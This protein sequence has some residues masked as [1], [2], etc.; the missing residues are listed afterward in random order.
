MTIFNRNKYKPLTAPPPVFIHGVSIMRRDT[1]LSENY[2]L[3]YNQNFITINYKGITYRDATN[4]I[5]KYRLIGS[6]N[7]WI[8]T[9]DRQIIYAFLRPGKYR[10]EVYAINSEGIES[11]HSAAINFFIH[12][13][14][15]QTWWFFSIILGFIALLILS[16]IRYRTI[17]LKKQHLLQNDLNKYRQQALVR[18]M[19]PHFVFNTLNSIQSFIIKNDNIASIQYLSK[20]SRLMRLILNN[21][22]KQEVRLRDEIDALNLYMELESMRFKHKFEYIINVDNSIDADLSFI[23][24][25]IVQPFI[26]NAIWHG[27]M[28]LNGPGRIKVDFIADEDLIVCT[29]EDNGIGRAR[30]MELKSDSGSGKSSM[31]ISITETRLALLSSFYGVKLKVTFTDVLSPDNEVIGTKVHVNLPVKP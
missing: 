8:Y 28:N 4:L 16:F 3:K 26:E 15:W 21:S 22:Q 17:Q 19:D 24:A 27:I 14:F 12:P 30:S 9:K 20:F 31:G 11:S 2:Y 25:F 23:P 5:Y 18:Q 10:F 6:S 7:K 29:I 1:V 13:P